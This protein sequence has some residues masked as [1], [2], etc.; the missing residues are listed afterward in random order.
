MIGVPSADATEKQQ[1]TGSFVH[2]KAHMQGNTKM[3][4]MRLKK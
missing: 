2:Q 1:P 4:Q 3:N